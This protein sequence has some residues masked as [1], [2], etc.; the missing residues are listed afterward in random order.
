MRH[1]YLDVERNNQP[2]PLL[3]SPLGSCL[4]A[5]PEYF[6]YERL[7][8]GETLWREGDMRSRLTMVLEGQVS[9]AKQTGFGERQVVLG[10]YGSG[11]IF[12]EGGFLEEGPSAES[13]MARSDSLLLTLDRD[14]YQHLAE[15]HP[16]FAV[17]LLEQI[18][19]RLT[20]RL[21]GANDRLARIF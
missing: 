14:G 16:E 9:L 20:R 15:R 3:A 21:Q 4:M 7:L 12:G 2:A 8:A 18:M 13:A 17:P 1:R 6:R 5:A 19:R 11:A 10:L